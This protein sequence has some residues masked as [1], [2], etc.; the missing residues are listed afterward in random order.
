MSPN[1]D[2][3][4][5]ADLGEMESEEDFTFPPAERRL[6]TQPL[7]LSVQTLIEQWENKLLMLLN[8]QREYVWD[9]G[10]ASRL[11]ESLILNVPIPTLYFAETPEAKYEIIDGHQRV[12]SIVRYLTN[13]F[14]LS[15]V[16]V[17]RE[18]KGLRFHQ[19]PER[20]QRFLKMRTLRIILISVESH[21]NMKFEIY[22]RLNTGAILLNAQELRNSIYRGT[23]NNLLHELAKTADFRTMIGTKL[24]RRR[25]VD[26][27]LV[28]RFFA[29]S[30]GLGTYR[31]PLKR[32][33]N[34]F[35]AA[36]RNTEPAE[37]MRLRTKFIGT[38]AIVRRLLG[39]A[40]FRITDR[41][42]NSIEPAVNR[43]L[44]D[45]HM[46]AF[47]WIIGEVGEI[48]VP[49][50]RRT[51]A[52]LFGDESFMDAIQRATGDRARTLKRI[53]ETVAALQNGG[54]GLQVPFD[55]SR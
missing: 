44:F 35:M 6:I 18:Y 3:E 13:E 12:R 38:T 26:E 37:I 7:D 46:L 14:V 28:L 47:S 21:P 36:L 30:A 33:L 29:L 17:L 31:T 23:L 20:E 42:G 11:I 15:G 51:L 39:Q 50:V 2:Y 53:R 16:A 1:A 43:A 9:N 22:E 4:S 34:D 45:A 48:D 52:G 27:E 8:I 10:K 54:V 55:L 41:T 24:P 5:A 32:F 25:M 49:R 19:L 40:A